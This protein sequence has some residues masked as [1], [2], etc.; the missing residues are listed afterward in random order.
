MVCTPQCMAL[1]NLL[2]MCQVK[3]AADT[4]AEGADAKVVSPLDSDPK[5]LAEAKAKYATDCKLVVCGEP[6][7]QALITKA[8]ELFLV[9]SE[10]T[11]ATPNIPLNQL[12]TGTWLDGSALAEA[13]AK[14]AAG[15]P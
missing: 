15:T 7:L 3:R 9:S 5:T 2:C 8:G 10:D 6:N 12:G 14:A 11:I 4:P 13:K 1:S